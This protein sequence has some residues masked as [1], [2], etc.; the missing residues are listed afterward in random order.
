MISKNQ[1]LQ[2]TDHVHRYMGDSYMYL[3]RLDELVEDA[4][5]ED[6]E[7][8]DDELT[9]RNAVDVE[10]LEVALQQ[11]L[12]VLHVDVGARIVTT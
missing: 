11:P 3:W 1:T 4:D 2:C 5:D 12:G 8:V 10:R 9:G 6:A 7:A